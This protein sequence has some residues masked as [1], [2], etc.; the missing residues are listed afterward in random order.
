MEISASLVME[1]RERTGVG[2]MKC[3]S[4]LEKTDGDLE[5]AVVLLREEGSASAAKKSGR[6][7][8]E[9]AV[10]SYIHSG[11]KIGVLAEVNCE[12]DFAA[13]NAEFQELVRNICMQIAAADPKYVTRDEVDAELVEKEK[14]IYR[15]QGE[16]E[17]KPANVVEKIVEGR[18]R[19]FYAEV[20]LYEQPFVKDNDITIEKLIHTKIS[21]IGEN[22]K[23]RRFVR[24][25]LGS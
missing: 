15:K 22:I 6:T 24:Y 9:G 13:K 5:K 4:A 7:T 25:E 18:L 3:K 11:G 10:A 16:K 2:M 19:K 14:D 17:G 20:C 12:T 21:S 1:L 23:V 8:A